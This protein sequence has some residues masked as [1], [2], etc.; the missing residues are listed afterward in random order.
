MRYTSR[1]KWYLGELITSTTWNANPG[2]AG[3]GYSIM[4]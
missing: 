3:S 4:S 1:F 2:G